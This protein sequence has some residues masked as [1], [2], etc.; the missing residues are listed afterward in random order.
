MTTAQMLTTVDEVIDALGG[1]KRAAL[2]SG[3]DPRAVSNWR[4]YGRLPSKLFVLHLSELA[5]G[6]LD[7]PPAL[8][9]QVE[10]PPAEFEAAE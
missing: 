9:G 6:G 3:A 2:L 8:W 10:G 4:R 5:K 1:T 7:A